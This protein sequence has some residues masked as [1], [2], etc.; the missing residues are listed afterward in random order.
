MD[1]HAQNAV[2]EQM[3]QQH[4]GVGASSFDALNGGTLSMQLV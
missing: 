2:N 1:S 3:V 4:A